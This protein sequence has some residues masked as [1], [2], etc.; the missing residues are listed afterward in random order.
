M[1]TWLVL[2][3]WI[4]CQAQAETRW[5]TVVGNPG[6]PLVDT[7]QVDPVAAQVEGHRKTMSL[8]V[9]RASPRLNWEQ[10]PYR[11]YEARVVFDCRGRKGS[12]LHATYYP[13]PLWAGE[14]HNVTDYSN[15]PRPVL[16]RDIEP[17]PTER[18]VRAA[19]R[20]VTS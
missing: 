16:F 17:N 11:S 9:S 5:F 19:C 10:L 6:D 2:L 1:R 14:P 4:G 12:Y 3:A 13:V 20:T 7:V 18:I 8:R 15:H